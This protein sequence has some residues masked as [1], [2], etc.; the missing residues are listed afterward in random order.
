MDHLSNKSNSSRNFAERS[1]THPENQRGADLHVSLDPVG[2]GHPDVV[3]D[4]NL[5]A[6]DGRAH[7]AV[8]EFLGLGYHPQG[9]EEEFSGDQGHH[10][11]VTDVQRRFDRREADLQMQSDILNL[12]YQRTQFRS[13]AQPRSCTGDI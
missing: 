7:A 6:G 2:H 9:G 4:A 13:K 11:H 12:F 1:E 3:D 8:P 5:H 10:C